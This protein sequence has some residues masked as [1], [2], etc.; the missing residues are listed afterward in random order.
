MEHGRYWAIARR[1]WQRS[2]V[3]IGVIWGGVEAWERNFTFGVFCAVCVGLECD[4]GAITKSIPQLPTPLLSEG[5]GRVSSAMA[6]DRVCFPN[7]VLE[8]E[9]FL[10]GISHARTQIVLTSNSYIIVLMS[11][12]RGISMARAK[13]P[14]VQQIWL[15][16]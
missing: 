1:S 10:W 8:A 9:K 7:Q 4:I 3:W 15:G 12:R 5:F 6:T 11:D 13:A 14:T 16:A 2:A